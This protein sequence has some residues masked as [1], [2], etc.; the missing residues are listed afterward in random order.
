MNETAI[1]Y[2]ASI[3]DRTAREAAIRDLVLTERARCATVARAQ[4]SRD[5]DWDTSYW[6]QACERI[7]LQI[8]IQS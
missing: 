4:A 8:E 7:A 3:F 2:A 1:S 5:T 6:N